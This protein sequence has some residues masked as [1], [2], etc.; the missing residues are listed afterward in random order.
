MIAVFT[1]TSTNCSQAD[2]FERN[3]C[4]VVRYDYRQRAKQIGDKNRDQEII[5]ICTNER[6]DIVFFSKC[7]EVA[8]HVVC[9]CNFYS[10][11]VLWYMDPLNINFSQELKEKIACSSYAFCALTEPYKEAQKWVSYPENHVFFLQEGF[12]EKVNY[13]ILTPYIN[14]VAFIGAL[15]NERQKYYDAL[16]FK[17]YNNAYNEIHSEVVSQTKINLNFTEGGT[18]DRTYKI[19]A[20]RGFLLTQPWPEMEKDFIVKKDLDIF[21]SIDELKIQIDYYLNHEEER[22]NIANQGYQ[23]VQKFNRTNFAKAILDRVRSAK[24]FKERI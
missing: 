11:T 15:R 3:G 23:T 20:S 21:T 5:N 1:P 2:G 4:Q 6:P 19:L 16:K 8:T 17:V 14:D 18:S 7:N 24:D 22:V 13:P 9:S 10:V 12:D